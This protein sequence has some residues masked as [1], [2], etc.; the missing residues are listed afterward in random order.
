MAQDIVNENQNISYTNL[1]FSSIYTE[2]IDLIKQLTYRWD[3]SISDESD[4]GVILVKLSA[5]IA[6]KCNYNID[7]NILETFPLSVTQEGN[8]RQ[9]YD[10][11]G[12][13]MDWYE[14]ASVPVLLSWIGNT[15]DSSVSYTIP[16]FTPIQDDEGSH[17]YT[18]VGHEG[19]D[20][21]V[22]SNT[23]LPSDGKAIT[24]IAMEGVATQYQFENEIVITSQMVDPLSRRL[25]FPHSFVS[26]NG[27]F[28]KNTDQENYASWKRVN[29]LYEDSFNQLRYVFGYDSSSDTCFLEFPDNYSEL[30]G[31]GIEI[32]YLT[33]PSETSDI[34]AQAL[35]QFVAPIPVGGESNVVLDSSNVKI[36]NFTSAYGHKDIEG[37]DDAYVNYKRTVGTFKTL[38][39]LRDYLNF[40]RNQELDICSN[41]FVCDRTNDIQSTYKIM[42]K[43]HDLDNL[44]VK[45]EQIVDNTKVE[46]DFEYKFI[47]S[48]D[49]LA[50]NTKTYYEIVNN[51]LIE[52]SHAQAEGKYPKQEG[53]YELNSIEPKTKDALTPFSLKFY[54]LR[55]A[56]AINSKTAYNETFDLMNPYPNIDTILGD[57]AH[58]EHTYED[59]LPFGKNTYKKSMDLE[60][61]PN[62]S[63]WSYNKDYD[64]YSLISDYT[65]YD[66]SPKDAVHVY[67]I[68]VEAL[69]PHTILFKGVYPVLMNIST[70]NILDEDTQADI[71]S[72]IIS[73]LYANVNSSQVDFSLPISVD[74]LSTIA[75]NSDDRIKSVTIDPLEYSVFATYYDDNEGYYVDVSINSDMSNYTPA[76]YTDI[77]DF[78]SAL[79]KKDIV[80]KSILAG[81]TQLLVPDK[82]FIFHLSQKHLKYIDGISN[83]TG[84]A[85]I[86]IE[87]DSVFSYFIENDNSH[88]RKSYT[89]KDNEILSLYRPKLGSSK[90][91]SNN[92]HYEYVIRNKIPGES[93]YKLGNNEYFIA[94][95]PA[96]DTDDSTVIGYTAYAFSEGTII[97]SSF[98]IEPQYSISSLSDFARSR[99]IPYFVVNPLKNSYEVTTYNENYKTEIRNSSTIINNAI[100]G[101]NEIKIQEIA[102]VTINREDKYKF[103]WILNDPVY[104]NNSNLKSYTLFD[105]YN[106]ETQSSL[107]ASINSYTLRNGELLL[108]TNEDGSGL[109]VVYPGSTITRNCGTDIS[110]YYP[111]NNSLYYVNVDDLAHIMVDSTFDFDTNDEGVILPFSSG[112]FEVSVD[113]SPEELEN[114]ANPFALGLYEKISHQIGEESY[115]NSYIITYDTSVVEDKNYYKPN[116][117]R[118]LDTISIPEKYYYVLVMRKSSGECFKS[119]IDEDGVEKEIYV[120][121]EVSTGCFSEVDTYSSLEENSLVDPVNPEDL[122]LYEV[123]TKNDYKFEDLYSLNS[124]DSSTIQN[125]FTKTTDTSTVTRN[126]FSNSSYKNIVLGNINSYTTLYANH[127]TSL[128]PDALQLL[129]PIY[130]EYFINIGTPEVPE[131]EP[132]PYK[133][134]YKLNPNEEGLFEY[135]DGAYVPTED[136]SPAVVSISRSTDIELFKEVNSLF[137][138]NVL[139]SGYY[140]KVSSLNNN[141]YYR[142]I[143][144][145]YLNA[146]D[147]LNEYEGVYKFSPL[148]KLYSLFMET[149]DGAP[150]EGTDQLTRIA[151][152]WSSDVSYQKPFIK[153][154]DWDTTIGYVYDDVVSHNDNSWR[155][156]V[157][158][159]TVGQFND[160]EWVRVDTCW[161]VPDFEASGQSGDYIKVKSDAIIETNK[162]VYEI[163]PALAGSGS[164]SYVY[165]PSR[166]ASDFPDVNHGRVDTNTY[167]KTT[168]FV[169]LDTDTKLSYLFP[170]ARQDLNSGD[171][172]KVHVYLLPKFYEFND[173]IKYTYKQY[174]EPKELYIKG[175][176]EIPAWSCTA[177]DNDLVADDPIKNVGELWTS[178]QSN[179]SLTIVNNEILSFSTGDVLMFEADES[180][181]TYVKWPKFS[182]SETVLD[183]DSYSVSYQKV[184][185]NIKDINYINVDNYK[186]KGYSSLLLNTSSSNG[187]KLESNQSLYLYNDSIKEAPIDV[188]SGNAS[189]ITFQ[190]RY[191]VENK[192]GTYIDVST[193]DILGEHIYNELYA[194]IPQL[195]GSDYAYSTSDYSTDL[196]FNSAENPNDPEYSEDHI[197]YKPQSIL[198]PLGIPQGNYLLGMNMKDD[199]NLTV[200]YINK[201]Q[202]YNIDAPAVATTQAEGNMKYTFDDSYHKYLT[203]YFDDTRTVFSKDKYDYLNLVVESEYKKINLPSLITYLTNMSTYELDWFVY[204]EGEYQ[205]SD[206]SAMYKTYY[207]KSE[208]D[209]AEYSE[210]YITHAS[211]PKDEGLYEYVNDEY[212]LTEDTYPIPRIGVD[213]L[214]EVILSEHVG[215]NPSEQGWYEIDTGDY[216]LSLDT[217]IDL[218][219]TYYKEPDLFINIVDVNSQLLF[220]ID[221]KTTMSVNYSILDIFKYENNPALGDGFNDIRSKIQAL[222]KD[223]EYNYTFIPKSNDLIENPLDPK[224]F[225]NSNHV[226]NEFIIPQLNFDQIDFRYITT[227]MNK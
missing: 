7:K 58:L 117:I 151:E 42:S 203:S 176:G 32:T 123:V 191:P 62:K 100:S 53:W 94:Y 214:E 12:Y 69:L 141:F 105:T 195:N 68:D 87:N 131:Y 27:V 76:S 155:C 15:E 158:R 18:I 81:T 109:E 119:I 167:N 196:Y 213:L 73:S 10:Q 122:G 61:E 90:T 223:Q 1:D 9:L 47:K 83:I 67:E 174:Y 133:V 178:L 137:E 80:C 177:L 212:T 36:S 4:P 31:S 184:G 114:S 222:D 207:V 188:L 104:S 170:N 168:D 132:Y 198:L 169:K 59:I 194:F 88:I 160:D 221:N 216:I 217:S 219:K 135:L 224:S 45:V 175:C 34:P 180:S 110:T 127:L 129:S 86:D 130:K 23:I 35:N 161:V 89:L 30:F 103:F 145:P 163:Y 52:I 77:F 28:I 93:S 71:S 147:V 38:V 97:Y 149:V 49:T 220:T 99:I 190:L 148:N 126:I 33:I 140:Y 227:K 197:V 98:D 63:Y 44:I 37:L 153:V 113:P 54:L 17:V 154:V 39:T 6:D 19:T 8:A 43:S 24:A 210:A 134:D 162:F 106:S 171:Y 2:V 84:E 5:L 156:K 60:W 179:T 192:A 189:G 128:S 21:V 138:N 3:P 116:F 201:Q 14:S 92:I 118:S 72:N 40:I 208:S 66:V 107:S 70:Y 143:A 202:S 13:Y 152:K 121:D 199:I 64:T 16:K 41:A 193:V 55:K 125:R 157:A 173:F 182:N 181:E 209:P 25:Y 85:I 150:T 102:S 136:T 144:E 78:N 142:N 26:Q 120:D 185:E 79:I 166:Y 11:L 111:V 139:N 225:W 82:S 95:K 226:Y 183:L 205:S 112:L 20:E 50:D 96:T 211:N 146:S 115:S 215:E 206:I 48:N 57:T 108:Y 187:Q 101:T 124:E 218:G 165:I 172:G 159:S 51:N 74:Y 56:I 200:E 65:I 91:F 46:S 22:V 204:K 75:V 186:W 164:V 29:N